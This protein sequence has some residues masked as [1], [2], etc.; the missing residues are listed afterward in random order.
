MN[1]NAN[2]TP[3][4]FLFVREDFHQE[5]GHSSDLDQKRSG[6]LLMKANHKEN[7]TELMMI[8]FRESGHPVF[9]VT[10]PLSLRNAQKQRTWKIINTF[11]R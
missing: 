4:S 9:R 5:D 11:L 3:T 6:V 10:S 7:G 8:K 2:R 1:R